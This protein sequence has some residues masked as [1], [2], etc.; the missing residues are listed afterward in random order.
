[1]EKIIFVGG[2]QCSGKSYL[3][4]RLI[5]KDSSKF[6]DF[7]V[8]DI[9]N[10]MLDSATDFFKF[11]FMLNP[12]NKDE[13][14]INIYGKNESELIVE[15]DLLK[16]KLFDESESYNWKIMLG[17]SIYTCLAVNLLNSYNEGVVSIVENLF[18]DYRSRRSNFF[19]I[20]NYVSR[21]D[22]SNEF[23]FD[24]IPKT[25][26]YL[27]LGI[28]LSLQRFKGCEKDFNVDL[29]VDTFEDQE[30]PKSDEVPNLEVIILKTEGEVSDFI[31]DF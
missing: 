4:D 18:Y 15:R 12:E 29:I 11:L 6:S 22:N 7:K 19:Y 27:D 24:S 5:E 17:E 20:D 3:I 28:E 30:L 10:Q 8:D 26:I 23:N 31:S 13:Y 21:I 16:E 25:L 9:S 1:M 14:R 2:I